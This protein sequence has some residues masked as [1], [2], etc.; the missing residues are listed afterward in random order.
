MIPIVNLLDRTKAPA[1]YG[2]SQTKLF[3][4]EFVR[5][6]NGVP[7]YYIDRGTAELIRVEVIFRIA[8]W[9]RISPLLS[10]AAFRLISE[11]TRF[12]SSAEIADALDF[13]GSFFQVNAL[14]DHA[15]LT[16][17]S[18]RKYLSS[19]LGILKEILLEANYPGRELKTFKVNSIQRLKIDSEKTNYLASRAFH[20]ALFG[21]DHPYGHA[22][23]EGDYEALNEADLQD[24]Y[25]RFISQENVFILL[26]GKVKSEDLEALSDI[27]GGAP[28]R[29]G[30][31]TPDPLPLPVASAT[32]E[33]FIER[34]DSVQSSLRIGRPLLTKSHPDYPGMQILS[35][36]LG[37]YFGSRLMANI[38]EDKGY[39]YGIHSAMVSDRE[40]GYFTIGTDVGAEHTRATITEIMFELSRLREELVM[41]DELSLIR[42]YLTG[43]F[44]SSL[45]NAFSYADKFKS[46]HFF[47]LNYD[48]YRR[49]FDT[50]QSITPEHLRDLAA[51]YFVNDSFYTVIA[52][53]SPQ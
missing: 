49:Y 28:W 7:L 40:A 15:V 42:N 19:S 5:L 30:T 26:S 41:P 53:T 33:I 12:R 37:G 8:S 18:L 24:Y 52:G 39:T 3:E 48:Y 1:S 17:Y 34:K 29:N 32:K 45:E 22:E 11:G 4:P 31:F 38:R 10:T 13:Y 36:I 16:L 51:K 44:Q 47:D 20:T 2:L 25:E 35:T 50:L 9:S 43:S 46:V 23:R 14:A 21:Q 27:L 6:P